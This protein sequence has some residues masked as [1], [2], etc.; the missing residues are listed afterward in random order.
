MANQQMPPREKRDLGSLIYDPKFRSYAFQILLL[1]A[2]VAFVIYIG[3]NTAANLKAQNKTT[4]FDFLG[5]TAGFN[6]GFTLIE[7]D[8][9][10]ARRKRP[11]A[12]RN[13]LDGRAGCAHR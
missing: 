9:S 12:R 13:P 4:G 2:I 11:G 10:P 5:A 8:R 1:A 7:Y 3:L 6:I